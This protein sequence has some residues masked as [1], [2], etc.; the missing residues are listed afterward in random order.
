MEPFSWAQVR[1]PEDVPLRSLWKEVQEAQEVQGLQGWAAA[2]PEPTPPEMDCG[3]SAG[4][5]ALAEEVA[6]TVKGRIEALC[7]VAVPKLV[8]EAATRALG[9]RTC[10]WA[11]PSNKPLVNLS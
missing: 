11:F 7:R 8:G 9:G 6:Q 10:T 4:R 2:P 5:R 1:Q 3:G